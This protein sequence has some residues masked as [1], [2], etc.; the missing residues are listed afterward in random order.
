MLIDNSLYDRIEK[1]TR[2]TYTNDRDVDNVWVD[3]DKLY[4]LIEDLVC[5]VEHLKAR[6]QYIIQDIE[7]NYRPIPINEQ[8][9]VHDID[10]MQFD[11]YRGGKI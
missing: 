2:T 4:V 3:G 9:D 6:E 10:F 5:E 8:L 1:I 11:I 7:D